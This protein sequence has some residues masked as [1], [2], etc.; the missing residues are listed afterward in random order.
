MNTVL[1]FAFSRYRSRRL[2]EGINRFAHE[3][4]WNVHLVERAF[5]KMSVRALL[6]EFDPIGVI[7]GSPT[8]PDGREVETFARLP[9]V[10]LN[11]DD[12]VYS[13]RNYVG[14]DNEAVGLVAAEHLLGG[15]RVGCKGQSLLIQ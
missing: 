4:G 11:A 13:R 14:V 1:Y 7:A 9:V 10:Y 3:C 2:L 6:D 12:E 5:D 8:S 15:V